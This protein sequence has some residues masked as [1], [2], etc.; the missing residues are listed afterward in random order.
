MIEDDRKYKIAD[1]IAINTTKPPS[2]AALE[3]SHKELV[4]ALKHLQYFQNPGVSSKQ[5]FAAACEKAD[6]ALANA[7]KIT[8]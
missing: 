5:I 1:R 7:A 2:Y 8:K 4:E 3:A 6:N